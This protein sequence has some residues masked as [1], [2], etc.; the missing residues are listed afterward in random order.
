M[1]RGASLGG[2]PGRTGPQTAAPRRGP[3][4]DR[5]RA[6]AKSR[7]PE[8]LRLPTSH[9]AAD[10]VRVEPAARPWWRRLAFTVAVFGAALAVRWVIFVP[11]GDH[12]PFLTFFP[13]VLIAG[14]FA[15]RAYG[16]VA[17][18]LS[19][20]AAVLLI[21]RDAPGEVP[22]YKW[23]GVGL[24]V[25]IGG[26]IMQLCAWMADALRRADAAEAREGARL[27]ELQRADSRNVR[28]LD[29][30]EEAVTLLNTLLDQAPI[31]VAFFDRTLRYQRVNR[32]LAEIHG[33]PSDEHLGKTCED[34]L[35]GADPRLMSGLRRVLETRE[36]VA[37][38]ALGEV[39][40]APGERRHLATTLYPVTLRGEV[41]GVGS[42]CED[43]TPRKR[44]EEALDRL[45]ERERQA[46]ANA[47]QSEQAT[48]FFAES[49]PQLAWT[50]GA[51]GAIEYC[52]GQWL[53]YTGASLA[54]AQREGVRAAVHP[55]DAPAADAAWAESL[56]TGRPLE[57]VVRMRRASDG[58][59]RWHLTRVTPQRDAGGAIVRWFGTNTDI[60]DLRRVQGL[61]DAL[62]EGASA[63]IG[64][65]D[66]ELRL[67][68]I[69]RALAEM[70]GLS[71]QEHLGRHLDE[72][73][74]L[75]G[76]H[77]GPVVRRVVETGDAVTN[78][79]VAGRAQGR[80]DAA[81]HTLVNYYPIDVEGH[82]A[83]L[84]TVAVDITERKQ[85]ER[86]SEFLARA[87]GL[88]SS[89]LG[90]DEVLRRV[91]ALVA[92]GLADWCVLYTTEEGCSRL[93]ALAHAD[94]ARLP[95]LRELAAPAGLGV[96]ERA[97][98]AGGPIFAPAITP[99]S[100]RAWTD[101]PGALR[102][103]EE[104]QTRAWILAPLVARGRVYGVLSL[105]SGQGRPPLGRSELGVAEEL[106]RRI[107]VVLDNA[108]LFELARG[109]RL[110]AEEAARAK[111]EFLAVVSH[112][113]RTPLTPILGYARILRG[114]GLEPALTSRG[115]ETIERNARALAQIVEDLLDIS[116]IITGKL[117]LS[118]G[119]VDIARVVHAA[120]E[121]VRMAS[122]AKGVRV[123]LDVEPEL[124]PLQGDSDRLQQVMWNLVSNAVKFTPHEGRVTVEAARAGDHVRISV[125][126]TG[127]GIAPEFLPHVFERFRQAESGTTRSYG[128]LGLG[129]ALVRHIVEL[130]GGT[131]QADSA[132]EGQGS[133][134]TVRLPLAGRT[135]GAPERLPERPQSGA[136]PAIGRLGQPKLLGLRVLVVEDDADTRD[137]L[138][139]LLEEY[140]AEVRT[141]AS[142]EEGLR[143]YRAAPADL[144]LSD[145]AMPGGLDGYGLI[146]EIRGLPPAE[147]PDVPALALTAY[148]RAEDQAR[149]R[150]AGFTGHMA[151]PVDPTEL[152]AALLA[153]VGRQVA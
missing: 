102:L 13:A 105:G 6:G 139:L 50:A 88:L 24:F 114:G 52:N 16:L 45:V 144:L 147:R 131:V 81:L 70:Y 72:L 115:L 39:P 153:A 104:L 124:P 150:E 142:G 64:L 68:R 31:G 69:N 59:Y 90:L 111:D 95:R 2:S 23:I 53:A 51:G 151:K 87:G 101:D 118:V 126:D 98:R 137:L 123:A 7:Y 29:E 89:T 63:G 77:L 96:L 42:L 9:S 107:G 76:A 3:R 71:A 128:G 136:A 148:A 61:V 58:A 121:T 112:E 54:D 140:G 135:E 33:M 132:G 34:A 41:I 149:A 92:E 67:V 27:A 129:L 17:V 47:E 1:Q 109:E 143:L 94:P 80:G 86:S 122:E 56:R 99:S 127:K 146:R 82:F 152:L 74:P 65:F 103:A 44:Q 18:G 97:M 35:P 133:R 28:L 73:L 125:T 21:L 37:F 5:E 120:V 110:R 11:L 117:R 113:L 85:S 4:I 43:I 36:R 57:L 46:R 108:R 100:A 106:G 134:F 78:L 15:G 32:A 8:P 19:A 48:R 84:A 10:W 49:I 130:H 25:A 145:I 14:V 55:D 22:M 40:G 141:A 26:G 138:Q 62:L 93:A 119:A 79:E 12:A 66:P 75:L 20:A 30:R 91:T 116:R 60:D 38:D 83:G